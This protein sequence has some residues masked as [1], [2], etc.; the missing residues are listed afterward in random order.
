MCVAE[1]YH[2]SQENKRLGCLGGTKNVPKAGTMAA[3][4]FPQTPENSLYSWFN[5]VLNIYA[6]YGI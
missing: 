4:P 1:N 6:K 2:S 5:L 3:Y